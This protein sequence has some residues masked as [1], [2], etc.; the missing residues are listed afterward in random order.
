LSESGFPGFKDVQDR[1]FRL[2]QDF[3]DLRIFRIELNKNSRLK[4]T[5]ALRQ[6]IYSLDKSG[7]L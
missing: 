7:L 1:I 2:N 6:G 4:P 5:L 3:Q